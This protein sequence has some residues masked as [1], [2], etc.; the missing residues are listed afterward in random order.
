MT[1]TEVQ[2]F[3][4]ADSPTVYSHIRSPGTVANG[5]PSNGHI[6]DDDDQGFFSTGLGDAPLDM[7]K[8]ERAQLNLNITILQL[9]VSNN[10]LV[11]ASTD[12]KI[13]KIDLTLQEQIVGK[14]LSFQRLTIEMELQKKHGESKKI[15]K[16]FLDFHGDHLLVNTEA[17]E[18]FYFS[19]RN[20]RANKGRPV[21]RFNNVHIESVAWN[22]DS[23][24]STTKEILLGTRDGGIM[25]TYLEISDLIP[26]A[27]YIRQLR[28]FGSPI[29]GL[30]VERKSADLRDVFMANRTAVN[31]FSGKV[32]RKPGGDVASLYSTFFDEANSG[33]FQ[34]LS[35]SNSPTRISILPRSAT[36]VRGG[37][38]N[39]YF[40]WVTSPGLFHG[41][42]NTAES[43][44]DDSIFSDATLLPYASMFTAVSEGKPILP[45]LSQFH[46]LILH[47]NQL[48]A[49]NRLN[50]R[51]TFK[52]TV[53]SVRP[54]LR[55]A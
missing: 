47:E 31:V 33:Q 23:T 38:T 17:G 46:V 42:I 55:I 36:D 51:V 49:V 34:E 39:A 41:S 48:V 25:E 2:D 27:R 8:V 53:P 14:N 32:T 22:T 15:S 37:Q 11:M 26:N 52:E 7:F 24:T 28:N 43:T 12:S 5:R 44:G 13:Y 16:I 1:S 6:V 4:F 40:A 54:A 35:G 30:H 20:S 3:G 9:V 50:N 29:I 45:A 18:T 10:I 19:V 21:S